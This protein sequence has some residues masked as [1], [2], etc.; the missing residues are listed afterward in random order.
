M[1][2][3]ALVWLAGGV[4]NI[5]HVAGFVHVTGVILTIPLVLV[6][7]TLHCGL[8]IWIGALCRQWQAALAL[9]AIA[10]APAFVLGLI[11]GPY[12]SAFGASGFSV[13]GIVAALGLLGWL[14]RFVRFEFAE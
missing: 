14:L 3:E 2:V 11:A 7:V 13:F 5:A 8:P 10:L 6:Q 4:S 12:A 1:C 9:Y